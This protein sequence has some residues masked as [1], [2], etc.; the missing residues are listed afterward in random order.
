MFRPAFVSSVLVFSL[1]LPLGYGHGQDAESPVYHDGEW[2]RAKIETTRPVG[3]S[4]AGPQ[5]GGFPEYLVR[6]EKGGFKVFGLTGDREKELDSA[7]IVSILL[8]KPGWRGDLLK[9]PI[10]VGLSWSATFSLPIPGVHRQESARYEVQA[11]EK[12]KTLKEEFHA[13]KIV[14]TVGERGGKAGRLLGRNM[15]YYYAPR[16]KAIVNRRE[17]SLQQTVTTSTLVD[18]HVRA[19]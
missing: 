6:A 2:W 17:E 19:E 5:L 4:V 11:W 12:V 1:I 15:T 10:S 7:I 16:A 18:F 8:G 13:F 3:V 9:F 14:M